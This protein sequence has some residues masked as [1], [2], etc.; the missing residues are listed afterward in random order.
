METKM[1]KATEAYTFQFLGQNWRTVPEKFHKFD[2]HGSIRN[3]ITELEENN[4][5]RDEQERYIRRLLKSRPPQNAA[6]SGE[7]SAEMEN[8]DRS[9]NNIRIFY[10]SKRDEKDIVAGNVSLSPRIGH[11]RTYEV[12]KNKPII[13]SKK[14]TDKKNKDTTDKTDSSKKNTGTPSSAQHLTSL[15]MFK[16]HLIENKLRVPQFM[17]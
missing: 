16:N 14:K 13:D 2:R 7:Q 12:P 15:S 1:S 11:Q 8:I 6:F 5:V 4:K 10:N 9:I 3:K 17:N